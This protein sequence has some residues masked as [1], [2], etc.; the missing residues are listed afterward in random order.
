MAIDDSTHMLTLATPTEADMYA[1]RT[2]QIGPKVWEK[3]IQTHII[4]VDDWIEIAVKPDTDGLLEFS[5][6]G[7]LW[8]VRRVIRPIRI[9]QTKGYN[10]GD[11]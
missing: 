4:E 11:N 5:Y 2:V 3:F 6:L 9:Y 10:H 8:E 7:V 1:Y